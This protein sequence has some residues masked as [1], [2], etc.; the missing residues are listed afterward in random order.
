MCGIWYYVVP[1]HIEVAAIKAAFANLSG[2]GP[3]FSEMAPITCAKGPQRV[4]LGFHRLAVINTGDAGNQPF[5][6][7]RCGRHRFVC[8]GEIYNWRQL[9]RVHGFSDADLRSDVD[10]ICKM[11]DISGDIQDILS[12]LDG[13]WAFISLD[14]Q[15]GRV[16]AGRDPLGVRP[17][18]YGV[19]SNGTVLGIASE[20]KGLLGLPDV[21]DIKVFPPGTW[22][23]S[24]DPTIFFRYTDVFP[25]EGE[26]MLDVTLDEASATVRHLLENAVRK[27]VQHSDV[28]LAFLC[29]GGLD[30]SAIVAIAQNFTSDLHTFSMAM[31]SSARSH[32][33]QYAALLT[34]MLAVDHKPITFTEQEVSGVINDVIHACETHDT[35]T[36]RASIPMYLLAKHIRE[37]TPYRVI[38]SGEGADEM[39]GGYSYFSR[40]PSPQAA[41]SET[42]RL[43]K[44]LYSFDLLR[45]DRCFAA[46]GL[47]IRVPYLDKDLIRYVLR[48]PYHITNNTDGVE[49]YLLRRSLR[50]I[51][52]LCRTRIIDRAK[53]RFSD[54]V[55][56]GYVPYLLRM[57]SPNYVGLEN[58][59]KAETEYYNR[60]FDEVY[61]PNAR[62]L[63]L[64]RSMPDWVP[65]AQPQ[66][67]TLGSGP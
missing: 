8:S 4:A 26:P 50:D 3:D 47:E 45:A 43:L 18:F 63:I 20:A 66:N 42:E 44:N 5:Q 35:Q 49:K 14:T 58:G 22:W 2:R 56:F 53:E 59:E 16:I 62:S 67:A 25:Q 52:S 51:S 31:K 38:L 10:I 27:R 60:I 65:R 61:K 37:Q 7:G 48:L 54:G 57:I 13:D 24:D 34:S 30:S 55:S 6:H 41:R 33:A 32:D 17:L 40:A 11:I 23:T 39:F 9:T 29:S 46:H 19:S 12:S 15:S 36:I 21:Q 28:P 1:E 64:P